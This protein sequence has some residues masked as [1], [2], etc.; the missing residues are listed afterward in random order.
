VWPIEQRLLGFTHAESGRILA[1][2]WRLPE[3]VAEVIEFHHCLEA[4]ES[5][6]EVTLIVEVANQLLE[7]RRR[8][9]VFTDGEDRGRVFGRCRQ[10][11]QW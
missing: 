7:I 6:H 5:N 8:L 11:A 9:W 3:E 2:L 4:Q 10:G 1:D